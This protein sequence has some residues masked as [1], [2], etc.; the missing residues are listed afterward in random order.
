MLNDIILSIYT[1]FGSDLNWS[2]LKLNQTIR[3]GFGEDY[4][5][6]FDKEKGGKNRALKL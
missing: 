5:S 4:S 3:F 6:I 1:K 2:V